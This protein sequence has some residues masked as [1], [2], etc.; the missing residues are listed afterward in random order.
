MMLK[1]KQIIMVNEYA[2]AFI[3]TYTF[4]FPFHL[5][6]KRSN[7]E[8]KMES[9]ILMLIF[10]IIIIH[11]GFSFLSL[12]LKR[13]RRKKKHKQKICNKINHFKE[14]FVSYI[15]IWLFQWRCMWNVSKCVSIGM[16]LLSDAKSVCRVSI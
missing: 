9:N 14:N 5:N 11:N 4:F 16:C 1:T 12:L 2:R 3:E 10:K 6:E 7:R 8:K 13:M 15:T